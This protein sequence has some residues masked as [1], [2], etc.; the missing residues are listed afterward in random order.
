MAAFTR[1]AWATGDTITADGL[2]GGKGV[3]VFTVTNDDYDES[4]E[5]YSFSVDTDQNIP[6][7]EFFGAYLC[8]DSDGELTY[9]PALSIQ[10]FGTGVYA[11]AFDTVNAVGQDVNFNFIYAASLGKIVSRDIAEELG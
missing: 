7:Q 3:P 11:V 8:L 6:M 1:N 5:A 10:P 9:I 2:N 4:I